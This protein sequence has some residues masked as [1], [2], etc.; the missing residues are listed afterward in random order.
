MGTID[1]SS[2]EYI[3][4]L[5]IRPAEMSAL[6]E[7]PQKDIDLI[8]PIFPLKG[9]VGSNHLDN[10]L[11]R[12]K[13]S[14]SN[15]PWIADIDKFFS[16]SET[17]LDNNGSYKRPV[18]EEVDNLLDS[19]NG[20]QNWF[21]FLQNIP[22]AVPTLQLEDLNELLPQLER[23]TELKRGLVANLDVSQLKTQSASR[24]ENIETVL[25]VLQ[26]AS[27]RSILII[28]N[29]G[30]ITTELLDVKDSI[31]RLLEMAKSK[32]PNSKIAFSGSSFPDGFANQ[33]D[34]ENPILERQLYSYFLNYFDRD[35]LKYSDFGSA[36]VSEAQGGGGP[37][38]PR[39][40][41]PL[42]DDWRFIR[43]E[44]YGD[45]DKEEIYSEIAKDMINKDYWNKS[46]NLWGTQLI[47]LTAAS[48]DIGITSAAKATAARINIH[49]YNQ[50]HYYT[51]IDEIDSDEDWID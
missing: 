5:A 15:R 29:L 1:F 19:K 18:F 41:Y 25:D 8:L 46:L 32:V 34:N 49:L 39:I 7:L 27:E 30:K 13:K 26:H 31:L 50:L 12:I 43:R 11:E 47:Y 2:F 10:T 14:I 6:E 44:L 36:R 37:P 23:L 48:D 51:P 42:K 21:E 9:W 4:I 45:L 24:I 28:F 20:Y 3:P 33:E 22:E 17:V 16:R 38:V 35:T 40:D